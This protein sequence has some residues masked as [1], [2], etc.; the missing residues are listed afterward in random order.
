LFFLLFFS[1]SPAL[2]HAQNVNNPGNDTTTVNQSPKDLFTVPEQ[3]KNAPI[4]FRINSDINYLN[5]KH[6]VKNESLKLFFQAWTKE[7]EINKLSKVTDSLRHIYSTADQ[8]KREEI[9]T[10]ILQAEQQAIVLNQEVPGIYEQA[11]SIE[12]MFWRSAT[13]KEKT[14]FMEKTKAFADSIAQVA[15]KKDKENSLA[16]TVQTDTLILFQPTT[17]SPATKAEEASDIVY[18]IQIGAFK[19]KIPDTANKLIKK[20][21]LIRNIEKQTDSKGVTIYTTGNLKS[22]QEAVVLQNQ[23]KQEGAKNPVITAYKNGKKIPLE[24]AKK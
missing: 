16:E 18:K 17:N 12:N 5:F 22:Y 19:N 1:I 13:E 15:A 6:F 24:E 14:M 2:L 8:N 23:V 21:S 7:N 9:A 11:R 20:L 3:F 4:D 10:L